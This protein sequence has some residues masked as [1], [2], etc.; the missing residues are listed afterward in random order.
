MSTIQLVSNEHAYDLDLGAQYI[1][2]VEKLL[3]FGHP[4][5]KKLA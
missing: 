5:N 4:A 2:A 1:V 3:P